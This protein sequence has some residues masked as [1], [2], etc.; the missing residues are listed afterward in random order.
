MFEKIKTKKMFNVK[1]VAGFTLIELMIVVAIIGILAGIV[2]INLDDAQS[3]SRDARRKSDLNTIAKAVQIY[4][5]EVGNYVLKDTNDKGG[6]NNNGYGFFNCGS[7]DQC[8]IDGG[9]Y[10]GTP[11]LN[12]VL[13]SRNLL[14]GIVKDPTGGKC[15]LSGC[16]PVDKYY[17]TYDFSPISEFPT[18]NGT[19]KASIWCVLENPTT[20]DQDTVK[21]SAHPPVSGEN[22]YVEGD[23]LI[24]SESTCRAIATTA[25]NYAVTLIP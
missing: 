14:S 25:V 8:P 17:Y 9:A 22:F 2:A 7:D 20:L 15:G 6:A 13:I 4:R 24:C 10:S 16:N 12:Q 23:F 3:K 18:V 1:K 11:S 5:E 21:A 19:L